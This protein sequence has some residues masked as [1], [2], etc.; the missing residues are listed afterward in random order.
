M[1]VWHT[2]LPHGGQPPRPSQ[3]WPWVAYMSARASGS[4]TVA[5]SSTAVSPTA[6]FGGGVFNTPSVDVIVSSSGWSFGLWV[7]PF[8]S[9][10][11]T[12]RPPTW[13]ATTKAKPL[14]LTS[15]ISTSSRLGQG[16]RAHPQAVLKLTPEPLTSDPPSLASKQAS[17]QT[18]KENRTEQNGTA[19]GELARA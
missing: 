1:K 14:M 6:P 11:C 13:R 9:P 5:R 8:S 15:R 17:K 7:R 3:R 10:P 2:D 18:H 12:Q 19:R 4:F 16:A